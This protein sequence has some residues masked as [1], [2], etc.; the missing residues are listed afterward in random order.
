[1]EVLLSADDGKPYAGARTKPGEVVHDGDEGELGLELLAF[2]MSA[3]RQACEQ[4]E[5]SVHCLSQARQK[6]W[7]QSMA[8][9]CC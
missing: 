8:E 4:Y 3:R 7:K 1:M 9:M 2:S 6:S 5:P